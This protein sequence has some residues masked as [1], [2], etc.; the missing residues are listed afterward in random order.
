LGKNPISI[1]NI[2]GQLCNNVQIMAN[3]INNYF[4]SP[5]PQT[6]D[7]PSTDRSEA[8]NFLTAV[9]KHPFSNIHMTPVTIKEVK[10]IVKS[11]KWKYSYGYDEIPQHILK[12]SLPFILAPLTHMCNK[13]LSLGVFPTRLKYSQ[14]NP[15][16]KKGDKTD[17]AN[18]RPI[19]LLTS[20]SKIFERVIHNRFQ[21]H[22]DINN[23]LAH[24]QHGFQTN[25]S[26]E[27]ATYDLINIILTATNNKLVVGGLFCDLTKAF[28]CVNHEILLAKLE[29][30][31]FNG[32]AGKLIKTYLMA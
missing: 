2:E 10:H 15:I 3:Y 27:S 14:I 11:L 29:F 5:L 4:V 16:F 6:K 24:E 23:I 22:L 18:Y 28:D 1:I 20:F 8:L 31:G 13:S 17:I 7:S 30:Y 32:K 12:I 9:F 21:Q 25:L 19:S 26:T